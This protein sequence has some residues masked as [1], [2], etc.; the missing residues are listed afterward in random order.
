MCGTLTVVQAESSY[1]GA[2]HSC[3]SSTL[4][5]ST[6]NCHGPLR[7]RDF[8]GSAISGCGFVVGLAVIAGAAGRVGPGYVYTRFP[9]YRDIAPERGGRIGGGRLF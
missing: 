2:N 5:R 4:S 9:Q 1:P 3:C 8:G 6:E 7:S